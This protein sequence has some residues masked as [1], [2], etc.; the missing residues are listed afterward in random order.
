[1]DKNVWNLPGGLQVVSAYLGYIFAIPAIAYTIVLVCW[2]GE[3]L[4]IKGARYFL[5]RPGPQFYF[6][7]G[8][9]LLIVAGGISITVAMAPIVIDLVAR[10]S[11]GRIW[12]IALLSWKE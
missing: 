7:I 2:I 6:T 4:G 12:A 8:D 9:W 1:G 10:I 11:W 5:P 3:W